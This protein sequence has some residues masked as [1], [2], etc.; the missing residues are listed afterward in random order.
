VCVIPPSSQEE[1]DAKITSELKK[2]FHRMEKTSNSFVITIFI[3]FI[4]LNRT[5]TESF[6][7]SIHWE[8]FNVNQQE[9]SPQFSRNLIQSI[10][11]A[12]SV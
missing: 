9:D 10:K 7:S 3:V 5:T 8:G 6:T 4:D 12:Y 11:N 1:E 2:L